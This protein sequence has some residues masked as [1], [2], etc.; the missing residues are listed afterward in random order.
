MFVESLSPDFSLACYFSE[1][2]VG[3]F[4]HSTSLSVGV[5]T[6]AGTQ[7]YVPFRIQGWK[8]AAPDCMWP[9]AANNVV[10]QDQKLL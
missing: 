9:T 8:V 4:T 10:L 3:S 1:S 6:R 7:M 2:C 5:T